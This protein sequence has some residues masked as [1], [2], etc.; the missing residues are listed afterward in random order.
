MINKLGLIISG[1]K[2]RDRIAKLQERVIANELRAAAALNGWDQAYSPP[3]LL[4]TRHAFQQDS[5]LGNGIPDTP[6]S[7]TEPFS[8]FG[9][10]CGSAMASPWPSAVGQSSTLLSEDPTWLWNTDTQYPNSDFGDLV[11]DGANQ[12]FLMTSEDHTMPDISS[13]GSPNSSASFAAQA[14]QPL[15]YAVTGKSLD[16]KI[17]RWRMLTPSLTTQKAHYPKSYKS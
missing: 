16:P 13:A 7:V 8:S 10:Y 14:S 5:G 1:R 4:G 6:L 3:P 11:S 17:I 12:P 15:Y 9:S 2:I